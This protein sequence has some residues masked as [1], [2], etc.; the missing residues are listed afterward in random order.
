[1]KSLLILGAGG[2]G[3]V[4]ADIALATGVWN[5]VEFYDEQYPDFSVAKQYLV[6]GNIEDLLNKHQGNDVVIG[7]GDN[8]AR[9]RIHRLLE[10]HNIQPVSV[11]HPS[12]IVSESA[13]VKA[14][15]VVMPGAIINCNSVVGRSCIVNSGAVI[16]HDCVLGEFVHISP[17]ATLAG[18]V[19][20]GSSSWV[21][22]GSCIRQQIRVGDNVI[23]GA[24]AVVVQDI[25]SNQVV[26]GVPAAP[27]INE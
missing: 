25:S 20:I 2:H 8:Q 22:M 13:E 3:R 4:I 9:A 26:A 10:Q 16:E 17:N 1:M 23:V 12:A 24:G 19:E 14:G 6:A 11:I 5:T 15:T 7:I 21:G 27:I 18:G